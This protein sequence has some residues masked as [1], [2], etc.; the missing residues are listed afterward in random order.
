MKY[1]LDIE[2][3][4]LANE[5]GLTFVRAATVGTHPRFIQMICELI[6]ERMSDNPTRPALGRFGPSHDVCPADCCLYDPR[7]PGGM[8]RTA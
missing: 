6:E 5:L 8:Q 2:A 7:P 4:N 3:Q 1:D